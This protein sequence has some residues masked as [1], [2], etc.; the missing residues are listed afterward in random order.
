M[1]VFKLAIQSQQPYHV[2]RGHSPPPSETKIS[3]PHP[4]PYTPPTALLPS[5]PANDLTSCLQWEKLNPSDGI[6]HLAVPK[7]AH[8]PTWPHLPLRLSHPYLDLK[9]PPPAAFP[10]LLSCTISL[11]LFSLGYHF[12]KKVWGDSPLLPSPLL[13]ALPTPLL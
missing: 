13:P 12:Q 6:S 11:S 1:S 8:L 7:L 3:H 10:L 5:V 9:H 4:S 2:F